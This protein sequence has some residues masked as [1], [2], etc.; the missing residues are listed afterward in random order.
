MNNRYIDFIAKKIGCKAWQVENCVGL[1]KEG[2]TVPFISRY[3]KEMTGSLSDVEVTEVKF[4]FD[5]FLELDKRKEA[6]LKTISEQGKLTPEL[7]KSI[8]ESLE[9]EEVEDIYLPFKPHR[10]T[11]AGVAKELGLE[12]F[13]LKM[14]SFDFKNFLEEAKNYICDKLPDTE[15][16]MQ[17]ARDIIAEIVAQNIQIRQNIR[18]YY[19]REGILT[20]T[21][22]KGKEE[23]GAKYKNYFSSTGRLSAMPSHRILAILRGAE[24]KILSIK[25][26]VNP[27]II[28]KIVYKCFFE[29]KRCTSFKL[30]EQFT[31]AI[32]DALKRLLHPSIENEV[33]GIM[34]EKA[35]LEAVKIFGENLKQLLLAPPIGQKRTLALDPGFRTGCKVV[36]LDSQGNL[37]CHDVIYPHPPIN[38]KMEAMSKITSLIEQYK[39]EAIAIGDG[40]AARE[41]EGFIKRLGL[42]EEIKIYSVSEDGASIYSASEVAREEFPNYDVTVRGAVSIGRRLQ[43]PLSELVKIEPRSLGVGQYQHDVNQALLKEKLDSVVQNCVNNVGVNLNTASYNL[44]S[45]V[46]GIGNSLSHSIV[47]YRAEKGAFKSKKELLK[48]K[49]LGDK[50][51]EQAAG[52]LRLP[53]AKNRLENTGVHP[54]RYK[55]VEQMAADKGVE[56]AQLIGNK[57]LIAAI[58]LKEYVKEDVGMPTLQDIVIELLKPGRDP[59][60]EEEGVFEFSD[61]IHTI[62]DLRPGMILGGIVTNITAFGAFVD[63]GIKESGL[64]HISKMGAPR[65]KRPSDVLKL[66]QPVKVEILSVDV[67]GRRISL[68]LVK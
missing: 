63:I 8:E 6:I 10:K 3:R 21:L 27:A 29:G 17:G 28:Q 56:V 50:A 4:L 15:A 67:P 1:I 46:A 22:I 16:V 64:I 32:E 58:D 65:G 39:I 35:D 45:Y 33:L 68:G 19:K 9:P 25:I 48:V 66:R 55:I 23:E 31:I 43:D 40:T 36:C 51:F 52:F 53:E 13:A 30:F 2:A 49:R 44:L 34:K 59:R 37:L 7:Q 14:M 41:T 26:E 60:G 20:S 12:P 5:R 54:E 42:G 62:E 47:E 24:E 11:R 38:K 18:E 61:I 57:E